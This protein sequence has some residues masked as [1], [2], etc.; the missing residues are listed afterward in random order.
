MVVVC[1]FTASCVLPFLLLIVASK[2]GRLA[3]SLTVRGP[4]HRLVKPL[5]FQKSHRTMTELSQDQFN[6]AMGDTQFAFE[7]LQPGSKK[8]DYIDIVG[9]P[10]PLRR[11][12]RHMPKVSPFVLYLLVALFPLWLF[13]LA[14]LAVICQVSTRVLRKFGILKPHPLPPLDSGHKA[15]EKLKPRKDRKYDIVVLGVTGFTGRLAARHLAQKYGVSKGGIKWA[16]AGRSKSKLEAVKQS[17]ADELDMPEIVK[18]IDVIIADTSDPT[19]MPA[20]VQDTRVI[21]TTAGP[22]QEYGNAVVEFAA[23]YGTHYTDIT[24]E[25]K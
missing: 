16:I 3:S 19:T 2:E 23:K 22:Y 24:G 25:S 20:L 13:T 11:D 9:L 21:A 6:R 18:E 7:G 14:P 10:S 12:K 4:S 17:L 1:R 5:A 15:P 8:D